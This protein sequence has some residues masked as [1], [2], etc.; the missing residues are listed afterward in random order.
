[1]KKLYIFKSA[2]MQIGA[3]LLLIMLAFICS[4]TGFSFLWILLPIC[5]LAFV[6][7]MPVCRGRETMWTYFLVF[8]CSI[9][10]N[11]VFIGHL[12]NYSSM[13]FRICFSIVTYLIA[14][15][16]EEIVMTIISCRIWRKQYALLFDEENEDEEEDEVFTEWLELLGI[17]KASDE[18]EY[19]DPGEGRLRVSEE[20]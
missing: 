14:L 9:P 16:I 20:Q 1:M 15:S 7:Y 13:A 2:G 10:L 12:F 19:E 8:L 11:L 5:I 3:F 18:E 17:E 4:K 6:G